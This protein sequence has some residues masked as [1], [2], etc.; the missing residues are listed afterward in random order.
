[1]TIPATFCVV[2]IIKRKH[3]LNSIDAAK[4][5][6]TKLNRICRYRCAEDQE[7]WKLKCQYNN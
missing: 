6:T 5:T 7:Y 2:D 3:L 1:L 4:Q